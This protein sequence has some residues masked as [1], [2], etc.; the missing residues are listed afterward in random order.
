[1]IS[2]YPCAAALVFGSSVLYGPELHY[3]LI[4]PISAVPLTIFQTK[5][6]I[7]GLSQ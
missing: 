7:E 1:V 3:G 5:Y 6:Q 4:V 2:K